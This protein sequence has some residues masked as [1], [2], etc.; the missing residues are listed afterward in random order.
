M[1]SETQ[2]VTVRAVT[3]ALAILESFAG[4][5]LQS[6]AEVTR[7]TGLDKGTTRRLLMTMMSSGFI[8][9]DP[10][11]QKYGLGRVIRA[12]APNVTEGFDIR[13]VALPV[14]NALAS[15]F[16]LTAFL[17][18]YEETGA[19]CLERVHDIRGWRSVGGPSAGPCR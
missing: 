11:T 15:E 18:V 19:V 6:L 5:R 14:L 3:R 13:S 9:Q 7:V 17:S 2:V 16:Q 4:E 12:L 8:I 10:A 1:S